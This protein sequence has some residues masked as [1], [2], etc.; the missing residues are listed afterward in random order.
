MKILKNSIT[1]LLLITLIIGCKKDKDPVYTITGRLMSTC[2][3]P[4]PNID[5]LLLTQPSSSSGFGK[6]PIHIAFSSDSDGYFKIIFRESEVNSYSMS[7]KNWDTFLDGISPFQDTDLGDVLYTKPTFSF[8]VKLI[9]S[10]PYTKYDTL[11]IPDYKYPFSYDR[12]Y[13]PGPFTDTIIDTIKDYL[14]YDPIRYNVNSK[15]EFE[16]YMTN[17]FYNRKTTTITISDFCKDKLYN[18]VVKVE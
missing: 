3:Q 8:V 5:G 16:S 12:L 6:E 2:D 10:K 14:F 13:L 9:V 18:A 1:L 17:D 15:F 4:A 7:L 11:S